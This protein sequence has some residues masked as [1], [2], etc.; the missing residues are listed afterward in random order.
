MICEMITRRFQIFVRRGQ[1]IVRVARVR[2]DRQPVRLLC[3]ER[4][5]CSRRRAR[6]PQPRP[7]GGVRVDRQ[8]RDIKSIRTQIS[9]VFQRFNLFP[10]RTALENVIEGPVHVK[11]AR[12]EEAIP[13]AKELLARVGLGGKA[14]AYPA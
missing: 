13:R 8:S 10:H 11:G 5:Q 6:A 12:R 4:L 14:D 7:G 1:R 3:E 2:R 9:M